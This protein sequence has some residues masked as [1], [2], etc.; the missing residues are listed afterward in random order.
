[1]VLHNEI[2]QRPDH[3]DKSLPQF[4]DRLTDI[5]FGKEYK[6]CI[7]KLQGVTE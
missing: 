3:L 4:T 5:L 2:F 7:S 1:M 6:D